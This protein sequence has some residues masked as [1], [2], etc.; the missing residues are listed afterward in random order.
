[1]RKPQYTID[2][3]P[4]N[5]D[6]RRKALAPC[7][8]VGRKA[9]TGRTSRP[10]TPAKGRANPDTANIRAW[11]EGNGYPVSDRGRIHQDVPPTTPPTDPQGR[12]F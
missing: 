3:N 5:A 8:A 10:A 1:M 11:A 7:I 4:D 2:L 6:R 12:Q 9:S